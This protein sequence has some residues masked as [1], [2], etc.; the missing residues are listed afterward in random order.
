MEHKRPVCESNYID[1]RLHEVIFLYYIY[2]QKHVACHICTERS[3]SY[4]DGERLGY[5]TLTK[6]PTQTQMLIPKSFLYT[7]A[8]IYISTVEGLALTL[9]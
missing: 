8:R 4:H 6:A 9:K 1:F 3:W 2:M 7:R 5:S